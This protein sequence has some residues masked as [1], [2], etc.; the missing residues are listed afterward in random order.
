MKEE[1]QAGLPPTNYT[2]IRGSSVIPGPG[3][4]AHPFF[5]GLDS[6]GTA[7]DFNRTS[8]NPWEGPPLSISSR[9][10]LY[11]RPLPGGTAPGP[12]PRVNPPS[13][14]DRPPSQGVSSSPSSGVS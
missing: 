2:F 14:A 10:Q 3:V 5:E 13:G 12:L 1:C 7:P 4:L 9:R 8:L 11:H 6:C